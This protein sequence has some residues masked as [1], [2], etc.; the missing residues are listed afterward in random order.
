IRGDLAGDGVK[1]TP[2]ERAG[3]FVVEG[4]SIAQLA[5]WASE[6]IAQVQD[7][8][9]AEVV[10]LLGIEKGE[11]VLDRCCG[12]GTKTM[13]MVEQVG[14]SGTVV[15]VDP[16]EERCTILVKAVADRGLENVRV[17]R[18]GKVSGDLQFSRILI[19]A[20]CSNSGVLARRAEARYAQ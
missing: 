20:P 14:G 15:A 4:A 3:M 8:T 7:P 5:K 2:H 13:Q 6:G 16:S 19:D 11:S 18:T 12:V 9:A 10:S 17:V 1:I